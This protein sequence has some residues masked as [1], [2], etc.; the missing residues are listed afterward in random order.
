M[1]AATIAK[2][3]VAILTATL[4]AATVAAHGPD[5]SHLTFGEWLGA[6]GAGLVTGAGVF[7]VPNQST[8]GQA[9]KAVQDVLSR[10][11]A[12]EAEVQQV[13]EAVTA[14][15]PQL[16]DVVKPVQDIIV[17]NTL[18]AARAAQS[19]ADRVLALQ[20]AGR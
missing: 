7:Q 5:L 15:L 16:P 19:L 17:N 3:I 14:A 13:T 9:I 11:K 20:Y 18:D 10:Q 1:N 2:A 4:G 12:A 6:L 8:A